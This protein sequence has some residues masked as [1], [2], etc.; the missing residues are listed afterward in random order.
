MKKLFFISLLTVSLLACKST[1]VDNKTDEI[2]FKETVV[3]NQVPRSSV[4]FFDVSDSRCPE[5]G[6]CIWAGNATID[7]A[8]SGVTTEGG[9]TSH[10]KMCLGQCDK[11]FKVADTLDYDFTGQ[12]YR[13]ILSAVNPYPQAEKSTAK[14]AY[15]IALK[16]EKK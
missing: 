8:I 3:I 9:K 5:G 4:Q 1:S 13:F 6:E 7:L 11:Q 15:S 16:I 10:V 14:E 2:M 12:K